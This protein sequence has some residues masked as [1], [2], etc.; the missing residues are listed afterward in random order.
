MK[1]IVICADGT[2]NSPD[3]EGV[4]NVLRLAES[5]APVSPAG[6]KQVVFYDWGVG[7][8]RKKIMGGISGEGLDK[9]IM[10]CYRFIVQ[11]YDPA[12]RLFFFGFSRGAYTVRSL[13][14]MIRNCGILRR[15]HAGREGA[16]FDLY[17]LRQPSSAP[18]A[19]KSE[20]FRQR[21]SVADKSL[22]EFLGV[23]DTVGSLGIPVPVFG[24]LNGASYLFHDTSPSS[25]IRC[26]R[27][28][29]AIDEV[30]EDF[31]VGR[32]DAKSGL[33]LKEVWFAGVHSDVG[34]GY[35]DDVRL[36][37]IPAAWMLREA[38]ARG[39][40]IEPHFKDRLAD[41]ARAVQHAQPTGIWKM[42]GKKNRR[43]LPDDLV[44][45]SVRRRFESL[46][47][48]WKSPTF[49]K[50]FKEMGED[51]SRIRIEQ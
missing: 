49:R 3:D 7:T 27:H 1:N 13:A 23:W 28:A 14:G 8:D 38:A 34:G 36:S 2:W 48:E 51:W 4:T 47:S 43:I 10:D 44:H 24:I 26:A 30:R 41:N 21:Y 40:A 29:M 39:L 5:V 19:P 35:E 50:Y 22:I 17:R 33:D 42:R 20:E 32:W 37:E 15:E 9:N 46:G 11:N 18:G 6:V 45:E 12:D 31:P 25:I 16:A